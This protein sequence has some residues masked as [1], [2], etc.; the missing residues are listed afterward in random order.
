MARRG[1]QNAKQVIVLVSLPMARSDGIIYTGLAVRILKACLVKISD[2]KHLCL[3]VVVLD[4]DETQTVT[5]SVERILC[6]GP[7]L[8]GLS[9]YVW[10]H[11]RA[12]AIAKALKVYHPEIV[13]VLGGPDAH[14]NAAKSI[15]E[16]IVDYV[17]LG[18]AEDTFPNLVRSILHGTTKNAKRPS[19]GIMEFFE[20]SRIVGVPAGEEGELDR[21]P[22]IWADT[23]TD[24]D[25]YRGPVA[26][27]VEVSRGCPNR[28]SY[29]AWGTQS[30]YRRFPIDRVARELAVLLKCRQVREIFLLDSDFFARSEDSKR[31]MQ[32]LADSNERGLPVYACV[33]P[34]SLQENHLALAEN[35][36]G[37]KLSVGIQSTDP[38]VLRAVE[39]RPVTIRRF[40][41]LRKMRRHHPNVDMGFD[42]IFGLPRQTLCSL[43]STLGDVFSLFPSSLNLHTLQVIPGSKLFQ[44]AEANG[45]EWESESPYRVTI[46]DW[47]SADDFQ[48]ARRI[49]CWLLVV[50]ADPFLRNALFELCGGWDW[51]AGEHFMLCL[52]ELMEE[53]ALEVERDLGE[54]YPDPNKISEEEYNRLKAYLITYKHPMNLTAIV[55]RAT[56]MLISAASLC[57]VG[58]TLAEVGRRYASMISGLDAAPQFVTKLQDI[59]E[60]VKNGTSPGYIGKFEL[61]WD[62]DGYWLQETNLSGLANTVVIRTSEYACVLTG[63]LSRYAEK[64]VCSPTI[65]S[66]LWISVDRVFSVFQSIK[67]S[68]DT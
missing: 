11:E 5:A 23:I 35:A 28:C 17:V 30:A 1:V 19:H 26:V 58:T 53:T 46:T 66:G 45:L 27:E 57:E 42:V 68:A 67:Q 44:Q 50:T 18:E 61:G 56:D 55:S 40:A 15:C 24:F 54:Q 52:T 62:L 22:S 47:M 29:C 63:L 12:L 41:E 2:A 36:L 60:E 3:D 32:I 7:V 59:P 33:S 21:V 34:F 9:T 43:Q 49:A 39:R 16:G 13:I 8:V 4:L 48:Q 25:E 31:L 20:A 10:N 64:A 37:L 51:H 38:E 65:G 14:V 6:R